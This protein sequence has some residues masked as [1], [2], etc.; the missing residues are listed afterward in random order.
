VGGII[1][2]DLQQ[3]L[4]FGPVDAVEDHLDRY[5]ALIQDVVALAEQQLGNG[6]TGEAFATAFTAHLR[7]Q[8]EATDLAPKDWLRYQAANESSMCADGIR[9]W[10]ESLRP[11]ESPATA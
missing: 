3:L 2:G 10:W 1:A 11:R 6:A 8:A 9:L 5:A 4:H 7:L